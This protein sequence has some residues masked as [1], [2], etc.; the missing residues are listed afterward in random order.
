MRF[1]TRSL[2][3]LFLAGLTLG[4]LG[5]AAHVVVTSVQERAQQSA[6]PA[7][8][9]ERTFT[10]QVMPYDPGQVIPVLSAFGEVRTRRS[11]E[12]RAPMAGRVLELAPGFEDG[13]AVTAGQLLLR[14]DPSEALSARDLA[15]S[16]MSRAEAELRDAVRA[17]DL[18]AEDVAAAQEQLDLRQRTLD[19]RRDL[20]GRGV[21]TEAQIEEAELALSSARQA[22][23]SRRQALAQAEARRDQ[24][25]TARDRLR[26]TLTDAERRLADTEVHAGFAGVLSGVDVVEGGLVSTNER[27][28]TVIDPDDLEVAFRISTAQ[29]LRLLDP[30]GGLRAAPAQVSLDVSGM[31][32]TSPARLSRVGAG[33]TE[34]QSGRLLYATLDAPRGFRLGDFVTVRVD[35]PA[36]E[37]V[38]LLPSAAVTAA[39]EVLVVGPDDRLEAHP[40]EVLRRQ[41]DAVILRASADLAGRE[42]VREVGPM[43]GAGIL[44]QP[45]RYAAASAG[46]PLAPEA[47]MIRLDPER[48]A[49]LIA[50]VESNSRMPEPVRARLIAQLEQDEVP[51]QMIE[52]IANGP[53]GG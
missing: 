52:R 48:R 45:Q 2:L 18:A 39:G 19:R 6:R 20:A 35:E 8:S 34:G 29:Y 7:M 15:Q 38:A 9:R 40:V 3:A 43:L 26:I 53:R 14:I 41:G 49:E 5:Y 27:L 28:A 25:E 36:L 16:D 31:E 11:L 4:L 50:Q 32:I 21:G 30:D 23:V 51:E 13:A 10:V 17:L 24:A 47:R 37:N 44:V 1:L 46:Q 12:L 33:L 42:V 22:L